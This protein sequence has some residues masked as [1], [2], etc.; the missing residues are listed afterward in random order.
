[1]INSLKKMPDNV[2][3]ILSLAAAIGTEFYLNILILLCPQFTQDQLEK[4]LN[5]P[6]QY[7]FI[8]IMKNELHGL[9]Y[10]Y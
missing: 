2:Q 3:N 7:G 8:S 9:R 5:I 6:I 1:M 4:L 10:V